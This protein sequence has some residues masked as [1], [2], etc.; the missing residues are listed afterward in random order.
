MTKLKTRAVVSGGLVPPDE[1]LTLTLYDDGGEM[2]AVEL[3]P[4]RAL[5]LVGRAAIRLGPTPPEKGVSSKRAGVTP[6]P[7]G[8]G[9]GEGSGA[10]RDRPHSYDLRP[11]WRARFSWVPA[12]PLLVGTAR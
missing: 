2:A 7:C 10:M 12:A 6:R 1:R 8:K 3:A 5:V 9:G 11:E 4:I